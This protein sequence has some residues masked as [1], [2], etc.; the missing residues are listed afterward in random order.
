[1][2]MNQFQMNKNN[3]TKNKYKIIN[4]LMNKIKMNYSKIEK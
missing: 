3:K 1:M 4:S 2:K